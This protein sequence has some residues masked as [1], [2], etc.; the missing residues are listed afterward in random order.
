MKHISALLS[1]LVLTVGCITTKEH[2]RRLLKE[3]LKDRSWC[4]TQIKDYKE[5]LKKFNQ[6]DEMGKLREKRPTYNT[7][8]AQ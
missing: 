3:R 5:R 1:L 6:L 8:T 4:E 7:P 2:E